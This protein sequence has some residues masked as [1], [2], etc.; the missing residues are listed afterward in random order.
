LSHILKYISRTGKILDCGCGLGHS[1]AYFSSLGYDVIGIDFSKRVVNRAKFLNKFSLNIGDIIHLPYMEN[2]FSTCIS[3]GVFEHFENGPRLP[4]TEARR[5]LKKGGILIITVPYYNLLRKVKKLFTSHYHYS[6]SSD[7]ESF[8]EFAF[9]RKEIVKQVEKVGFKVVKS[10][11]IAPLETLKLH[12]FGMNFLVAHF[13]RNFL[14]AQERSEREKDSKP[15]V[16]D[17]VWHATVLD[18]LKKFVRS[19]IFRTAFS[20]MILVIAQK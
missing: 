16:K 8:F 6:A 1:V 9:T 2:A 7:N 19:K 4:L 3:E 15:K 20:H 12:I 13:L 17:K 18:L 14:R 11:P 10:V 5:V